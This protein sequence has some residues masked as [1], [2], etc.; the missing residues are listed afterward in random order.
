MQDHIRELG[1]TSISVDGIGVENRVLDIRV[2]PGQESKLSTLYTYGDLYDVS[3]RV[4]A[5]P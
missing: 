2:P 4:S 5:Y 3:V 1:R